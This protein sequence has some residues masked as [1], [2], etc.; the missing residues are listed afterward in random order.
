MLLLWTSLAA[1][2]D[3]GTAWL[4]RID[5]ASNAGADAHIVL[6]VTVTD[7]KGVDANRTLEI[8]QKGKDM[9]LVR[10][11]EPARLAGVSLLVPDGDTVYVYLPAYERP[12]KRVVG[13]QRQDA[14]MGTDF[15]IEE[16]S[17]ME[18]APDY[19]AVVAEAE[20]DVTRLT[21]TPKDLKGVDYEVLTMW[22]DEATNMPTKIEYLADGELARRLTLE[23][24]R[25]V[26]PRP[27]AHTLRVEDLDKGT[28]T[29]ATIRSAE[30]DTGLEDDRFTLTELTR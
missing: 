12:P 18:W 17:R 16:L 4:E 8:W 21:L 28:K 9:R 23:D 3:A 30:L 11:T 10:F 22:V 2:D 27:L 13:G 26:G 29:A 1:A 7:R 20:G 15:S 5:T 24:Y 19:D 6:D 14:F 25:T